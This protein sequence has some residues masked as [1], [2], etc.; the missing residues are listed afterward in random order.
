MRV[1][2]SSPAVVA[3][4]LETQPRPAAASLAEG[5]Q[6]GKSLLPDS[7]RGVSAFQSEGGTRPGAPGGKT[8]TDIRNRINEVM[9]RREGHLAR[10]GQIANMWTREEMD[11]LMAA[12]PEQQV[13]IRTEIELQHRQLFEQMH[14][15]TLSLGQHFNP[16]EKQF[17]TKQNTQALKD[18]VNK[19]IDAFHRHLVKVPPGER[20]AV[21][22]QLERERSSM[23]QQIDA[24][25][26]V[27][28]NSQSSFEDVL[29]AHLQITGTMSG[30]RT[31]LSRL[32]SSLPVQEQNEV[33]GELENLQG[34]QS[35]AA[36]NLFSIALQPSSI[37]EFNQLP[38]G[39]PPMKGPLTDAQAAEVLKKLESGIQEQY[40]KRLTASARLP[41]D[42][43][44]R[45]EFDAQVQ[46]DRMLVNAYI[47]VHNRLP[48]PLSLPPPLP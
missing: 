34:H 39:A 20:S 9:S 23:L 4:T 36:H 30:A 46:R 42:L 32:V 28:E 5:P 22:M 16:H 8:A 18:S 11:R 27:M 47:N 40:Q 45:A 21:F 26:K 12:P 2:S 38:G 13:Q 44:P 31:T 33:R 15:E 41:P 29:R 25:A 43:R 37:T 35:H 3:R 10:A 48:R 17:E 19:T 14:R 7:H 24:S 1:A 6:R